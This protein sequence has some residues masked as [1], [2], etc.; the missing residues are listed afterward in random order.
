MSDPLRRTVAEFETG[1]ATAPV[2][3]GLPTREPILEG[4]A[5]GKVYIEEDGSELTILAGVEFGVARGNVSL[6]ESN[7]NRQLKAE[8]PFLEVAARQV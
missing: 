3:K 2:I 5:L 4:R 6:P 8:L 7:G 1:G